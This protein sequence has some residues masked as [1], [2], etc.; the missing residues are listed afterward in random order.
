[1]NN[2]LILGSKCF[3]HP[4]ASGVCCKNLQDYFERINVNVFVLG[5]S[6]ETNIDSI[7]KNEHVFFYRKNNKKKIFFDSI[8]RCSKPNIDTKLVQVYYENACKII[9]EE[10]INCVVAIY[11][12]LEAMEVLRLL[13][14]K[15]PKL[16]TIAYEV[17]S[18]ID[19]L[20]YE[21][22]RLKRQY[23]NAQIR[24]LKKI[25]KN[26]DYILLLNSH[27]K[28]HNKVFSKYQYKTK[29]IG[30]PF[31]IDEIE[32]CRHNK[33][34]IDFL[35]VGYLNKDNY[36][37]Q[38]IFDLFESNKDKIN[39]RM[40]FISRGNCEDLIEEYSKK[41]NRIIQHGYI[42]FSEVKKMISLFDVMISIEYKDKPSSIPAK[43]F[44]YFSSC[45]PIIHFYGGGYDFFVKNYIETYPLGLAIKNDEI[46]NSSTVINDFIDNSIKITLNYDS[47]KEKYII[48]TPQYSVDLILNILDEN[49]E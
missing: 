33:K 11:F 45:K 22:G 18:A 20:S 13:K 10:N 40:H 16:I 24:Y 9:D 15:Y 23:T 48:N 42:D 28:H 1:M 12:S 49:K 26:I 5:Y 8:K 37:P 31:L 17:D 29:V 41:D 43:V 36:S 35:Y 25:Y 3:Y 34:T 7:K 38:P 47:I 14:N 30:A 6:Y 39:W 44:N 32:D 27:I 46:I 19:Y 21:G 2:I 4:D